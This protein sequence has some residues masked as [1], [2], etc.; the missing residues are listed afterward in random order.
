MSKT[1]K[2]SLWTCQGKGYSIIKDNLDPALSGYNKAVPSY[3]DNRK[4]LSEEKIGTPNFIWCCIQNNKHNDKCWEADKPVKWFLE[5]P[6]NEVLSI[7]D[8]FIWNRIIGDHEYPRNKLFGKALKAINESQNKSQIDLDALKK[9][10]QDQYEESLPKSENEMW[11][12]LIIPKNSWND[13]LK[14]EF[15][16]ESYTVLIP[17]PAKESWVIF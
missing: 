4:K 14:E 3:R 8:T 6:I 13:I 16:W 2:L 12:R 1:E 17:H 10:Y 11:D 5:V 15:A 9:L 7:V